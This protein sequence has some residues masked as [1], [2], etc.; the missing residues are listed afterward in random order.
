MIF[1]V[2]VTSLQVEALRQGCLELAYDWEAKLCEASIFEAVENLKH[3][4]SIANFTAFAAKA[5]SKPATVAPPLSERIAEGVDIAT[6]L[7]AEDAKAFTDEAEVFMNLFVAAGTE[8]GEHCKQW[9]MLLE[10]IR[11]LNAAQSKPMFPTTSVEECKAI[12]GRH[13]TALRTLDERLSAARCTTAAK[14]K[15]LQVFVKEMKQHMDVQRKRFFEVL[16]EFMEK[17]IDLMEEK[18][19]VAFDSCLSVFLESSYTAS[20]A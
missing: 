8:A 7:L 3:E 1:E 9:A 4:N 14:Q 13:S 12:V 17:L 6:K 11:D 18:T 2:L 16:K 10:A 19:V 15:E 5:A 20:R